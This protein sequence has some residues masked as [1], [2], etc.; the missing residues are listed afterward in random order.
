[1]SLKDVLQSE[2]KVNNIKIKVISV[3]DE[4]IIVAD[5]SMQAICSFSNSGF[6]KMVEGQC[7]MIVRPIKQDTNF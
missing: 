4:N 6:K 2:K 5:S 7:Y 1:M 3:H